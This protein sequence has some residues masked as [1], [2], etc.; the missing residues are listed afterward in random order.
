MKISIVI[1]VYNVEPFIERCLKSVA[2]QTYKDI[3]VIIVDDCSPDNSIAIAENF[4]TTCPRK[5]MFRFIHHKENG[6]LSTARNTGIKNATGD[7]IFFLD[8]DDYLPIDAINVLSKSCENGKA[9][10]VVGNY[11]V[12][13][14]QRRTPK[15]LLNDCILDTKERIQKAFK[16]R[17]FFIMAWNKLIRRDFILSNNLFFEKGIIHEDDVWSFKTAFAAEY[18]AIANYTTYYY[19]IQPDS[20][21]G[22]QSQRSL[23]CRLKVTK[24]L[25]DL[26]NSTDY[27]KENRW[28]YLFLEESKS[29]YFDRIL[30]FSKDSAFIKKAYLLFRA[31]RNK[32]VLKATYNYKP[33]FKL[34]L[35]SIHYMLPSKIG[36]I[37]FATFVKILYYWSVVPAKVYEYKKRYMFTNSKR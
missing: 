13:G 5:E 30:Y 14:T 33:N 7:Y 10:F 35:Q 8:S 19:C 22:I 12:K 9:D 2:E 23:D 21:T 11:T 28:A 15:L 27:L 3:E 4:I 6:G 16:E 32:S 31:T 37:Y 20:I 1:P 34:F 17:L 26:I 18:V 25:Y 29:L 24:I 36:L